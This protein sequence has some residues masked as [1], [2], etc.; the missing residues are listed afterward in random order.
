MKKIVL[1][2]VSVAMAASVPIA[3]PTA[4]AQPFGPRAVELCKEIGPF[5]GFESVGACVSAIQSSPVQTCKRLEDLGLLEV[6]GFKNRG[7]CVSQ[8]RENRRG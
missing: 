8:I 6:L 3:A 1:T 5:L 7:D 2:A 4:S